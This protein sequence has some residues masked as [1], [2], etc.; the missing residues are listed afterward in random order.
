MLI[1]GFVLRSWE[2]F[3][4]THKQ[5]VWS[6]SSVVETLCSV[7]QAQNARF[8]NFEITVL[9]NLWRMILSWFSNQIQ[10][11]QYSINIRSIFRVWVKGVCVDG[12]WNSINFLIQDRPTMFIT[13][14][15]SFQGNTLWTEHH[16]LWNQSVQTA[17][18]Y[19]RGLDAT[20]DSTR[21]SS[22]WL[23]M[24]NG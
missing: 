21:I 9:G 12:N 15:P 13:Q 23:W 7:R 10:F 17:H 2:R 5:F 16:K 22:Y 11:D 4:C 1:F 24:E 8:Q 20:L 19:R 6:F 3:S 18:P 14:T